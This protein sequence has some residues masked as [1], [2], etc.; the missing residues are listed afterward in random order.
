MTTTTTTSEEHDLISET[1]EAYAQMEKYI[2]FSLRKFARQETESPETFDK[3]TEFRMLHRRVTLTLGDP[4]QATCLILEVAMKSKLQINELIA[5]LKG[6]KEKNF[7]LGWVMSKPFGRGSA[8]SNDKFIYI[9]PLQ[10]R[11]RIE[12]YQMADDLPDGTDPD[13]PLAHTESPEPEML[14]LCVIDCDARLYL[15]ASDVPSPAIAPKICKIGTVHPAE[16]NEP[17]SWLEIKNDEGGFRNEALLPCKNELA[18]EIQ[19]RFDD[20][21]EVSVR[22]VTGVAQAIH[23]VDEQETE[24]WLEFL[25]IDGPGLETLVFNRKMAREWDRIV[26]R[27]ANGRGTRNLL[28]GPTGNGKTSGARRAAVSAARQA[29]QQGRK[30]EGIAFITISSA[31]T[32]SIYIHGANLQMKAALVRGEA[33]AKKGYIVIVLIDEG[34]SMLGEMVGWESHHSRSEKLTGQSLLSEEIPGLGI[35]LT[36][37]DSRPNSYL[38]AAV[39]GRFTRFVYPRAGRGQMLAVARMYFAQHPEAMRVLGLSPEKA[40]GIFI[41]SL[42]S[43]QRTLATIHMQSG[44]KVP[45]LARDLPN[46]CCPR[47]VESFISTFMLDIED[48]LLEKPTI[49]DLIARMDEEISTPNL[50]PSNIFH[51]TFLTKPADDNVNIIELVA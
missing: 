25:D 8:T 11:A 13:D 21:E 34:D 51:V 41:D 23:T 32:G 45:V 29:L 1:G 36:M 17:F 14:S 18:Q 46:V 27:L 50:L 22:A 2:D 6:L 40:A 20:G 43:E 7:T 28:I 15:G 33:L 4:T 48:E 39:A 9:K 19:R 49:S 24:R 12:A 26:Q 16:E 44:R 31:T 42:F 3:F 30:V 5:V 38:P 47:K 35:F 10:E 37:N